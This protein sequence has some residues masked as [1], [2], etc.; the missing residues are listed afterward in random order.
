MGRGMSLDAASPIRPRYPLI[1]ALRGVAI[2]AMVVFHL[3]WDLYFLGFWN[4]DVSTDPWWTAFQKAIVSSFLALAGVSLWLGHGTGIRWRSFWRREAILVLA[5]LAVSAGTWFA[6]GDYF[7]FFGVLHAIA[8]FSLL[9]LPFLR[10][11]PLVTGMVGVGIIVL[12]LLATH[13]VMRERWLAWIGFW[14]VSPA[15]ADIVPVF[16]WLGVT[17]IGLA[18]AK[19]LSGQPFWRLPAP[20]WLAWLGRWSL[21]IYLL[22]QPLMYGALYGLQSMLP[23]VQEDKRAEEFVQ[24]CRATRAATEPDALKVERYCGCALEQVEIGQMWDMLARERTAEE[25]LELQAMV[26]LCEAMSAAPIVDVPLPAE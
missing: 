2:I 1:D 25:E 23:A 11:P 4:L 16:P 7:A 24:S 15:T 21:I 17:L 5:A 3:G 12:P 8:L 9:A 20:K 18:A 10:L 13:P 19:A 6:F 14:P 22:H 26:N